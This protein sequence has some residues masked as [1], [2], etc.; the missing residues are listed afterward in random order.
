M[1]WASCQPC[2]ALQQG[3]VGMMGSGIGGNYNYSRHS[4]AF[5]IPWAC[6]THHDKGLRCTAE[7]MWI[8]NE[9][10]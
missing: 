4:L 2:I 1:A 8:A 6:L 3:L 9:C 10:T 7:R 5:E